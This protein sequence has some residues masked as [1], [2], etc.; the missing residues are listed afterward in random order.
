MPAS[1]AVQLYTLRD[2][3]GADPGPAFDRLGAKGFAGV[4]SASLY[5]LDPKQYAKALDNAGLVLCSAHIHPDTRDP[6]WLE[7]WTADLDAHLVAGTQSVVIPMLLPKH[8]ADIDAVQRSADVLNA[9]NE[10]AKSRAVPLGY[11]NHFWEFGDVNGAPALSHFFDRCDPEVFAEIDIYWAA[12]GGVD[13]VS[14]VSDLGSRAQM[15]HVK[16]GPADS[17]ESDMV[18]VGSGAIA[19]REVIESN[20]NVEWHVIELDRCATDMFDAV[21]AS[22]DFL[23]GTGL[24]QGRS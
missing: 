15:L 16:D 3:I 19:T 14:F 8:F 23:V 13:P 18:A 10:V 22:Y 20:E 5:G 24:S 21:E 2:S 11:H 17:P 6:A 12:V 1:I 4:E 9:A 7:K